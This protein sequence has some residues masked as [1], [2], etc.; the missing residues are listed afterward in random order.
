METTI[1]NAE[2]VRGASSETQETRHCAARSRARTRGPRRI[3]RARERR[4]HRLLARISRITR[5][6][7]RQIVCVLFAKQWHG[8]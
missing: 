7:G 4:E 6:M 3:L 2:N 8:R 5:Q 1:D